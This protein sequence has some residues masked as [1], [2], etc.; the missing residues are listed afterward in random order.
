MRLLNRTL[1]QQVAERTRDRDRMWRLSTD[2]MLVAGF[3]G[4]IVAVNPAWTTLLGW[5]EAELLSLSFLDLVHP[6][7]R[8]QTEGEA[9]RLAKG[10]VTLRF[11]NRYRHKDG[12]YRLISWTAVPDEARIHAVGRD[13]T[14]E[15]DALTRSAPPRRRSANPR[16]WK[17][18]ASSPAA[19]RTTSTTCSR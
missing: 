2:I 19:S 4:Q 9:G 11:E 10:L 3:D 1:E 7:D 16:R 6:D 5:T 18:W 13:M 8:A 12:S 14:A 17:P 15:R